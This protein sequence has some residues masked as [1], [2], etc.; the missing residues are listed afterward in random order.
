MQTL[1]NSISN[2]V[3]SAGSETPLPVGTVVGDTHTGMELEVVPRIS[4]SCYG[5]ALAPRKQRIPNADI[6]ALL[7]LLTLSVLRKKS[8]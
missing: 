8:I 7:P 4:P 5:L 3:R 6:R 1:L 2:L